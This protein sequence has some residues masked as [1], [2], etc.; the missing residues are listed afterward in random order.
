MLPEIAL[1]RDYWQGLYR[2]YESFAVSNELMVDGLLRIDSERY[3]F[4]DSEEDKDT[5]VRLVSD[6]C[7]MNY[8]V[9]EA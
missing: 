4:L 5:V 8:G 9:S 3:N 6:I 1:G 2:A 7:N